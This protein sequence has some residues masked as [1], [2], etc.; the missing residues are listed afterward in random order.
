MFLHETQNK[1]YG[2]VEKAIRATG[3]KGVIIGSN[4]LAGDGISH[5]YNL[6]SDR[7]AGHV[8]RHNYWGGIWCTTWGQDT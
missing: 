7:L 1:Y 6:L 3:Y 8:D 2:R 5:Y 4:W